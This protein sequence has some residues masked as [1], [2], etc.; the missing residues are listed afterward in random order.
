MT[1]QCKSMKISLHEFC[2]NV[3]MKS[4]VGGAQFHRVAF[5][6]ESLVL[7]LFESVGIHELNPRNS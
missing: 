7:N 6:E 1:V 2:L 4:E 3:R 5:F